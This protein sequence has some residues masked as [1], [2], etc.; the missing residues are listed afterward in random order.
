V[1]LVTL[2][3]LT[4]FGSVGLGSL[5]ATVQDR[6][7]LAEQPPGDA[8]G[9]RSHRWGSFY[10]IV[11]FQSDMA[12]TRGAPNAHFRAPNFCFDGPLFKRVVATRA[13]KAAT[14]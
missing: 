11:T 1:A 5:P 6:A 10:L 3:A 12:C 13:C 9:H 7:P 4:G 2:K 14:D 8:G